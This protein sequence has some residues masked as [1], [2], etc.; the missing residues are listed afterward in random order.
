VAVYQPS[1]N[2][3]HFYLNAVELALSGP[4]S[5]PV[6]SDNLLSLWLGMRRNGTLP[7]KGNLDEV[8]I[9]NRALTASDVE[10]INALE[11]P[12]TDGDGIR[13]RF[14]TGTGVYV[15]AEDTGTNPMIRDTDGDGL[16][17]G[18]R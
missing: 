1:E 6:G 9:Y 5:K 11:D 14:E 15:S 4:S 12:D 7:F 10:Q 2:Q 16:E 18:P 17:D 8:R 13:D 3:I